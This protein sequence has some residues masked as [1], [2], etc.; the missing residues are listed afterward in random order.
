MVVTVSIDEKLIIRPQQIR[1]RL[2]EKIKVFLF[3][4][5]FLGTG[6]QFIK[7]FKGESLHSLID[8]AYFAYVPLTA[9]CK[10][11]DKLKKVYPDLRVSAVE[12]L[13]KTYSLFQDFCPCFDDNLN[14]PACAKAFY[15]HLIKKKNLRISNSQI[16]GWGNLELA[17]AFSH[18]VPNNC[19]P[20]LWW[21]RDSWHPLFD[22]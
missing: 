18:A 7:F 9:H 20:I 3:I 8:S 4:D 15:S 10:G 22:R 19:L 16:R 13:D 21:P 17:Y 14:N 11:I 1:D 2:S 12:V 6:D 5:D